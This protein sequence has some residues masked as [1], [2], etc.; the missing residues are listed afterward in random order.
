MRA[1]RLISGH[2]FVTPYTEV[3][4][5]G[6]MG[7]VETLRSHWLVAR[8]CLR[9]GLKDPIQFWEV[10]YSRKLVTPLHQHCMILVRDM[11]IFHKA[12]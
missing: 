5:G 9:L 7:M 6:R 4:L 3:Q 1:Q 10:I 2:N 11:Q 12:N 8:E